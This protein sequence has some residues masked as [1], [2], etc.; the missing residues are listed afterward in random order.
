M[1]PVSGTVRRIQPSIM[2]N[3]SGC[4]RVATFSFESGI[5]TSTG[6]PRSV[7]AYCDCHAP[8]AAQRHGY[9]WPIQSGRETRS[10]VQLAA[11]E[12]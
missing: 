3:Q 12:A 5:S 1:P 7:R 8:D 6:C 2:C 4:S 11:R 9:L 10:P